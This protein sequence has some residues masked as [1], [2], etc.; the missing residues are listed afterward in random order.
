MSLA[1]HDLIGTVGVALIVVSY[2]LLQAGKVS[3]NTPGFYV[4]NG[5]GAA[6]ILLSIAVEFNL[7]AFIMEAFWLLI[8]V[9]GIWRT[10]RA[11][12][13]GGA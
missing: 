11:R 13:R 12:R 6:L 2:G 10:L 7:S 4:V 5:I 1:W 3:S 9:V 8:S